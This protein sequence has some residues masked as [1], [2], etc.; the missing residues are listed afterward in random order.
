MSSPAT[1]ATQTSSPTH[2]Q[3]LTPLVAADA[4][5]IVEIASALRGAVASGVAATTLALIAAGA[6][7]AGGAGSAVV[8][9]AAAQRAIS[10]LALFAG[11]HHPGAKLKKL[12]EVLGPQLGALFPEVGV[13]EGIAPKLSGVVQGDGGAE[14]ADALVGDVNG[15]PGAVR[16]LPEFP[17]ALVQLAAE[18]AAGSGGSADETASALSHA[19]LALRAAIAHAEAA[20][21]ATTALVGASVL[22]GLQALVAA[23]ED[24]R[25]DPAFIVALFGELRT[26]DL[27]IV[28]PEGFRAW[29][30]AS[31]DAAEPAGRE[32]AVKAVGEWSAAQ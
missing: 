24:M 30:A 13:V 3:V 9:A 31:G 12:R 10:P 26:G 16:S 7:A 15:A 23:S 1:C 27:P 2:L 8:A 17:R 28:K 22:F 14:E 21:G 29:A 20:P 4:A 32:F 5:D 18:A 6:I 19:A 11:G 25:S